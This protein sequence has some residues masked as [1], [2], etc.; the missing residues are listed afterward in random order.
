MNLST[1]FLSLQDCLRHA[2]KVVEKLSSDLAGR[3][4]MITGNELTAL[5]DQMRAL[6]RDE[7]RLATFLCELNR[8]SASFVV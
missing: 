7:V 4:E 6:N 5:L 2:P 1:G 3:L 8:Q